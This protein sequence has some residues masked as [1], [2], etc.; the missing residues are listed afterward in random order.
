VERLGNQARPKIQTL[1]PSND[2]VI[3]DENASVHTAGIVQSWF[4]AHEGEL[5]HV[6]W[7]AQ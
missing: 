6:P 3:E 2:S 4:E 7:R 1:F 5:Q